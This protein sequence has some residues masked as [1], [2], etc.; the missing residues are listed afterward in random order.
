MAKISWGKDRERKQ[1]QY[2]EPAAPKGN[3]KDEVSSRPVPKPPPAPLPAWM[4]DKALLP[5]RP[6]GKL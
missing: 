3:E 2:S 6:P 4:K 5:K 1:M